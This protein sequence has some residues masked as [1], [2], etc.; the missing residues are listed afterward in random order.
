MSKNDNN[1]SN[2]TTTADVVKVAVVKVT[3]EVFDSSLAKFDD[4]EKKGL[5]TKKGC[6]MLKD[7]YTTT[8]GIKNTKLDTH[9]IR[10]KNSDKRYKKYLEAFE[11]EL[12][13][14]N[15]LLVA[16]GVT[17]PKK[18][19]GSNVEVMGI[20]QLKLVAEIFDN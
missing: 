6:E 11:T 3:R 17:L 18:Q 9:I 14:F 19:R 5:V 4:M 1:T 12:Q 16:D 10:L 7:D 13:S 2:D 8:H 15:K 20:P